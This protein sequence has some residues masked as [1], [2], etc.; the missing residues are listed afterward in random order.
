M[1]SRRVDIDE[2]RPFCLK[3]E[4][5]VARVKPNLHTEAWSGLSRAA[6]LCFGFVFLFRIFAINRNNRKTGTKL[7]CSAIRR[8]RQARGV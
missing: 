8:M 3:N 4:T 7:A 5:N 2:W 6:R 1:P